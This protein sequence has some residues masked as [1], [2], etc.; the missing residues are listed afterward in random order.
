MTF[1]NDNFTTCEN[2]REQRPVNTPGCPSC[3]TREAESAGHSGWFDLLNGW[4]CYLE[5]NECHPDDEADAEDDACSDHSCPHH[6]SFP[7]A[8][9]CSPDFEEPEWRDWLS[10]RNAGEPVGRAPGQHCPFWA[11]APNF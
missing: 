3:E 8:G 1:D 10:R 6:K 9:Q 11:D 7:V 5:C 2:C 4:T